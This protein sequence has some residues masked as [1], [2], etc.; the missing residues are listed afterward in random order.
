MLSIGPHS[1]PSQVIVAPMAGVTDRPFRDLCRHFGAYWAVSEMVTSDQTLWNTSKSRHRLAHHDEQGIRWVQLAGAEPKKIAAAAQM[2][3]AL[4]ADIIDLNMGCPAKKVCSKAAG[5]A[6][7][8]DEHLVGQI[9]EAVVAAVEVPVTLKMRLGWSRDEMNATVIAGIAE[10]AGIAALTVHGRTRAC[11]F[12][13]SVDYDAIAEVKRGVSIP[14]IA[15]GDINDAADA[16][17]VLANTGCDAVMIGRA[18]QGKPW[19]I[20]QIDR[21]LQS[22]ELETAPDL[23]QVQSMLKGHVAALHRFYGDYQGLRFARKH[24]GWALDQFEFGKPVKQAFNRAE[25]TQAQFNVID[26]MTH[27]QWAA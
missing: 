16:A 6:L 22:G 10:N 1:N 25:D 4:G 3:V 17:S 18:A 15:N 12:T 5:S 27:L 21:Y 24:V 9:L 13:G 2:N 11:R 14:V 7:L 19:L 20:G 8:R 26:S 23:I